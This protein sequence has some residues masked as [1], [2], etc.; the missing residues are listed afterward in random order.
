MASQRCRRVSRPRR[1]ASRLYIV[2]LIRIRSYLN[3]I[4]GSALR[5]IAKLGLV[6]IT[7]TSTIV[8]TELI[9]VTT[10]LAVVTTELVFV[11]TELVVVTAT[12][13]WVVAQG[14]A[15]VY[16]VAKLTERDARQ[17]RVRFNV[18]GGALRV[19]VLSFNVDALI[20]RY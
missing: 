12:I 14:V 6:I 15:C 11:T 4:G 17:G 10:E 16:T 8:T 20:A 1:L 13:I 9:V 2:F 3:G 19:S 7:S 18:L 5:A